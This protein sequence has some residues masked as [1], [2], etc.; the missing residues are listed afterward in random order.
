MQSPAP[1]FPICKTGSVSERTDALLRA[2]TSEHAAVLLLDARATFPESS[3]TAL[4]QAW[5]AQP[6]ALLG[7]RTVDAA[8]PQRVQMP[9]WR[10]SDIEGEWRPE[11]LFEI[12]ADPTAPE[13]MPC[14]WVNPEALLIPR[15]VWEVVGGFDPRLNPPLAVIDWCLRARQA[16]FPCFE[17]QTAVVMKPHT[18][19][20]RP[21]PW[22]STHL[23]DLPGMLT[24]ARKHRLPMG[25]VRLAWQFLHRAVS[26]EL[27]RVHYWADYGYHIST[28]KRTVWYLRNLLLALKR[29]RVSS[30]L[31]SV[32]GNFIAMS[33]MRSSR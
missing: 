16:G 3:L 10:W 22:V 24:L 14:T 33:S 1:P 28:P 18:T 21:G 12:K 4:V 6:H 26:K 15:K 11:W 7:V 17:V 19:P 32:L 5:R 9:G 25:R 31:F 27:G 2:F 8:L 13:F 23:A 30:I 20:Q 29:A